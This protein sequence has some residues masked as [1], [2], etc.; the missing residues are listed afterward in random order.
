MAAVVFVCDLGVP[1]TWSFAQ[2]VGG[3]SVGA[4]L[5]WGNMFGNLGAAAATQIYAWAD[6]VYF[7]AQT[8]GYEGAVPPVNDM[9]GTLYAAMAGFIVSGIAAFG[10]DSA[11]TAG[12]GRERNFGEPSVVS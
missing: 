11:Q 8:A 1:A 3:K 9:S 7:A 6:K 4:V 10:I 5:G 12:S 2:D